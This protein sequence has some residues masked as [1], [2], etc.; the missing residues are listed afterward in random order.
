MNLEGGRITPGSSDAGVDTPTRG[1]RGAAFTRSRIAG[2]DL[3]RGLAII[4]MFAAHS[5]PRVDDSELLVDGRPSILFATLAGISLGILTGSARPPEPG[6]RGD[7]VVGILVRALIIFILGVT[8]G[9]LDSGVAVILDFY[10]IMFLLMTPLLFLPR[11]VLAMLAGVI[12][13]AV[14]PLA[15]AVDEAGRDAPALI[16][17]A[18]FYLLNGN[19]PAL[20]WLPFLLVGL[21]SAR[22]DL[23]RA[24]TQLWMMAGGAAAA[25]L[26][27]G[28]AA[29]LAAVSAEAHSGSTAEIVASGGFAV[30]TIGALLWLTAPERA[31]FGA[32]VRGITWPIG[33]GGSMP[34][35]I[36][37]MQILT[38]VVFV[39]LRDSSDGAIEYPGWPLLIGMTIAALLFASVWRHFVGTGPLERVLAAAAYRSPAAVESS[40]P[41]P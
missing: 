9:A 22:S 32:A 27:Y 29:L 7:R 16:E 41:Q 18:Q 19:Y 2:V 26:G 37:T 12:T 28:A 8:L 39:Q 33:A 36:Y 30:A 14:P 34:L 4:G 25:V 21:I 20:V 23:R 10:A 1:P 5:I 17:A 31:G 15:T 11:W 6:R 40:S 35:T 24:R 38:L 13:V 3:A